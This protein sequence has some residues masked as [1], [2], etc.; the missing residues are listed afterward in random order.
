MGLRVLEESAWLEIDELYAS[1]IQLK[2]DLLSSVHG[3]V[4]VALPEAHSSSVELLELVVAKL[5]NTHPD[6]KIDESVMQSKLHPL[7]IASLLVQEDLVIMSKR[8]SGWI[9]IAACVCF[10]SR[11]DLPSLLGQ[12]LHVIHEPVPH[13]EERI[14][15]ATDAMFDKFTPERSV[16]RI[17][18]TILDSSE[19]HLPLSSPRKSLSREITSETF[20]DQVF[21]RT[22]RQTLKVLPDSKDVVFTIRNRV[23]SLNVVSKRFPEFRKQL[24][25]TLLTTSQA[26]RDYKGWTP[27]WQYLLAWCNSER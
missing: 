17:N 18:W 22:E 1:D 7:E 5:R 13:Y 2:K 12:N 8:E 21:F 14:G 16:W 10:P 4:F 3:Q 19:L 27:M 15:A 23:D 25:A 11:W 6:V 26:T 20:G 24:H 9:L